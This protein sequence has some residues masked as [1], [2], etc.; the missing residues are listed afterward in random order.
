[1]LYIFYCNNRVVEFQRFGKE[2]CVAYFIVLQFRQGVHTNVVPSHLVEEMRLSILV[3]CEDVTSNV[4]H[5]Q[6]VF[7]LG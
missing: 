6:G 7:K 5:Q 4:S 2:M 1:M 3:A